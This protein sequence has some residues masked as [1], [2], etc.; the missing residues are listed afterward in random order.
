MKVRISIL[1]LIASF[2]LM[3]FI[4]QKISIYEDGV[5]IHGKW[6]LL[7]RKVID[8]NRV[9]P[10]STIFPMDSSSYFYFHD[11]GQFTAKIQ[12]TFDT[13]GVFL[14]AKY[15]Q[16]KKQLIISDSNS[17]DT[18]IIQLLFRNKMTLFSKHKIISQG[19]VETTVN[20]WI[21]LMKE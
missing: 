18:F 19:G 10:E 20:K 4:P 9:H 1:C 15:V 14:T 17:S 21:Y 6:R 3:G 7:S 16:N 5:S 13:A 12:S 2:L 11:K 8:S